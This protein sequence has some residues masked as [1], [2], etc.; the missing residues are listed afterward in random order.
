[1]DYGEYEGLT[2]RQ[3]R[4]RRPGWDL[5]RDGCPGGETVGEVAERVRPLLDALGDGDGNVALFG[6][7]H[8]LRVLAATFLGLEPGDARHLFL[9]TGSVSVL[10]HEHDW[11]T[12][13]HWNHSGGS[14]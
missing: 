12:I 11:P 2:T 13:L 14:L 4:E 3:I 9:G 6:H 8:D 5:F 10:G 1:M 7:G